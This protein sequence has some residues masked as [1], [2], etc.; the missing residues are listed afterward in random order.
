MKDFRI[1]LSNSGLSLLPFIWSHCLAG[2][3][4]GG[5]GRWIQLL[6]VWIGCGSIFVGFSILESSL[7]KNDKNSLVSLDIKPISFAS[8]SR[9]VCVAIIVFGAM[10]MLLNSI[11]AFI[12]SLVLI[13]TI[14]I[15]N[16]LTFRSRLASI[17]FGFERLLLYIVGALEAQ[18]GINGYVV[19]GGIC[20]GMYVAAVAEL[21]RISE[22]DSVFLKP[23]TWLL[24]L[25]PV[26]GSLLMNRG[27][28]L[29]KAI[30][31]DLVLV[32]CVISI[33]SQWKYK[34]GFTPEFGITAL[35]IGVVIGDA[36]MTSDGGLTISGA[37]LMLL[38]LGLLALK[39][40][41]FIP[42]L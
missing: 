16:L 33:A 36:I 1:W 20:I 26:I 24:I 25:S 12:T 40:F 22:T 32:I 30:I 15:R 41:K 4:L 9:K 13:A 23:V 29:A 39:Y 8:R 3:W 27:V 18:V 5:D 6:V 17:C 19:I 28:Y 31:W 10:I 42:L 38:G 7:N 35:F 37:H 34:K 11:S 21:K 14:Y 2:W